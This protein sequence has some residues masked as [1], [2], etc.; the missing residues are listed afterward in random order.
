MKM[1]QFNL[2]EYLANPSR[3][4]VTRDGKNV[5]I[6]CTNCQ[7][8]F[9]VIAEIEGLNTS[10]AFSISGVYG[11]IQGSVYDLFF[12]PEKHEGYVNIYRNKEHLWCGDIKR[13][14]TE[15]KEF[16]DIEFY[17]TTIKIEW[18]E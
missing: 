9:P 15:A 13:T 7:G 5:T 3:K 16:E 8:F 4:V 10:M 17:I 1:K 12:A 18:E 6:H 2:E 11:H 14:E